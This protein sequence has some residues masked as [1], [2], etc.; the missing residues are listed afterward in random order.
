MD[1]GYASIGRRRNSVGLLRS[2]Q[3]AVAV[4]Y[5]LDQIRMLVTTNGCLVGQ[6]VHSVFRLHTRKCALH[7]GLFCTRRKDAMHHGCH[8]D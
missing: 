7:L 5:W 6:D 2:M 4:P 8:V 1:P 3:N